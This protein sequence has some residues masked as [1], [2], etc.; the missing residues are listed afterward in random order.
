[1]NYVGLNT[2]FYIIFCF[3]LDYVDIISQMYEFECYCSC[4]ASR[5]LVTYRDY[6]EMYY[7]IVETMPSTEDITSYLSSFRALEARRRLE[8]ESP[9][10]VFFSQNCAIN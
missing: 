8:L 4:C 5:S 3:S 7:D 9:P 10:E 1:M 2:R 6:L